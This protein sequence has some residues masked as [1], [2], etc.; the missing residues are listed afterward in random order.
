MARLFSLRSALDACEVTVCGGL[1]L[2]HLSEPLLALLYLLLGLVLAA[3]HTVE[4][5]GGSTGGGPVTRS[6]SPALYTAPTSWVFTG[7]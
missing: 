1:S 7:R 5:F 4:Q 3:Q 6:P 2:Y